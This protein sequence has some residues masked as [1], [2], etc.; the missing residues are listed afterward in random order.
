MRSLYL[1][2]FSTLIPPTIAV[3]EISVY[4]RIT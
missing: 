4:F 2:C 3:I 1:C